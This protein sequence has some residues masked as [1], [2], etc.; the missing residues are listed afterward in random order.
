MIE[1]FY[2]K[3]DNK[4]L[5]SK[6]NSLVKL[7]DIQNYVPIYNKF[8]SL[9]ETNF[10]NINLNHK[11]S[12]TNINEKISENIYNIVLNNSEKKKNHFLNFLSFSRPCKIYDRKI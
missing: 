1:I 12:I 7:F 9:T 3:N 6:C 11:D 8:F 10:N 2:Q 5:F 4:E